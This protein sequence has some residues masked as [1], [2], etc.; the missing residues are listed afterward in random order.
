MHHP[1]AD[2]HRLYVKVK[3]EGRGLLNI[4]A[5]HKSEI[6]DIGDYLRTKYK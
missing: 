4:E 3:E 5:A 2:T 1:E 6:R